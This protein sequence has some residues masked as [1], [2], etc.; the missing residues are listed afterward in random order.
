M[1][2]GTKHS[3]DCK[4]SFGRPDKSGCC[5][6]CNEIL[7]GAEPRKGWYSDPGRLN[8]VRK[9]VGVTTYRGFQGYTT[10]KR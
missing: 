5:E 7:A 6:R 8:T 9:A 1:N 2:N 10:V 4:M 3:A